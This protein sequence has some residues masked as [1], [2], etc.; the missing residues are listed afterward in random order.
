MLVFCYST[1]QDFSGEM[2]IQGK[3][4]K[5]QLPFQMNSGNCVKKFRS[6]L[7]M[8]DGQAECREGCCILCVVY[9]CALS[10]LLC[11]ACFAPWEEGPVWGKAE[12]IGKGTL[13]R[14][15]GIET[16]ST[17]CHV[18]CPSPSLF[19]WGACWCLGVGSSKTV[20]LVWGLSW[21]FIG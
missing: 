3:G 4:D 10:A 2:W 16:I 9:S 11:F 15:H 7:S 5:L 1:K 17:A 13:D 14:T 18:V 19:P 8:V 12:V 21:W 20:K 6:M